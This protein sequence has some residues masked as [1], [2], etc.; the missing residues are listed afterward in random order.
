MTGNNLNERHT[1]E[2]T[3][4]PIPIGDGFIKV[5]KYLARVQGAH[6]PQ[7][8]DVRAGALRMV[9]II[10][11]CE[12]NWSKNEGRFNGF[13]LTPPVI[14]EDLR[15][16]LRRTRGVSAGAYPVDVKP[17]MRYW[18]FTRFANGFRKVEMTR[19]RIEPNDIH[20]RG[21]MAVRY[22]MHEAGP[23]VRLRP[24]YLKE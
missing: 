21:E 2:D 11:F 14:D 12:E 10:G 1:K 24:A 6:L 20:V 13:L 19:D 18:N 22:E 5:A 23:K 8:F 17:C 16:T 15:H 9:T 3:L 7:I 4:I